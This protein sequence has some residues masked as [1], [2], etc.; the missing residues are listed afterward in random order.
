[1]VCCTPSPACPV[2]SH[3]TPAHPAPYQ[4]PASSPLHTWSCLATFSSSPSFPALRCLPH[5]SPYHLCLPSGYLSRLPTHLLLPAPCLPQPEAEAHAALV[6]KE[7]VEALHKL[8]LALRRLPLNQVLISLPA[9]RIRGGGI[10][11]GRKLDLKGT[12]C[13]YP[14]PSYPLP[15]F[16]TVKGR[17]QFP[18]VLTQPTPFLTYQQSSSGCLFPSICRQCSPPP[19]LDIVNHPTRPPVPL[20]LTSPTPC[21]V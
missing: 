5:P 1:M 20:V 19:S 13:P 2:P 7:Q 8:G 12:P 6:L 3:P 21:L 14:R 18:G 17:L 9:H 10:A 11:E 4:P 15:H 16:S